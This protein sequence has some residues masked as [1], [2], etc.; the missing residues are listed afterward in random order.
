MTKEALIKGKDGKPVP[1]EI[2]KGLILERKTKRITNLSKNEKI[3]SQGDGVMKIAPFDN[4]YLFTIYSELNLEDIPVDIHNMGSFFLTF[5]DKSSE[6]R[7]KNYTN[8][9]DVDPTSGQ[10]LFRISQE[11]AEKILALDTNIFYITSMLYDDISKSDETVLY[12]GRF[13]E[14]NDASLTSL[15]EEISKLNAELDNIKKEKLENEAALQK[16]INELS[17][18]LSKLR[19][20]YSSLEEDTKTYKDSYNELCKDFKDHQNIVKEQVNQKEVEKVDKTIKK[21]NIL[22]E[23]TKAFASKYV[24]DSALDSLKQNVIG[25]KPSVTEYKSKSSKELTATQLELKQELANVNIKTG[26][27]SIY[28]FVN[29]LYKF[30]ENENEKNEYQ[31]LINLYESTQNLVNANIKN[32]VEF[33]I[34]YKER[35]EHSQLFSKYNVNSNCIVI[36]KNNET[37]GRISCDFI[38][39][40]EAYNNANAILIEIKSII[41]NNNN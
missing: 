26:V 36:A 6:V 34:L 25:I 17:D 28:A 27:V 4:Y 39:N 32:N 21:Y 24:I 3:Y 13:A 12:S 9:K 22:N 11:E 16:Q 18:A 19:G 40:T 8:T 29:T 31:K 7:I 30:I 15:T 2:N 1:V 35:L 37:I 14:Y 20:E 5:K 33:S 23:A 10:I 38:N 41:Q